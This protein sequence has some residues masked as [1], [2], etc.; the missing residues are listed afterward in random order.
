MSLILPIAYFPPVSYFS[1]LASGQEALLESEEHFVKQTLRNRC[2]I[3]GA[4]GTL[5]LTVP[6]EHDN[7]WRKPIRDLRVSTSINWNRIHWKS[8]VS[9][10]GKST[11]FMY[12]EEQLRKALLKKHVF[13]W[14][15]NT[16]LLN[17][18]AAWIRVP[19]P[20]GATDEYLQRHE[21]GTDLRH[22]WDSEKNTASEPK[23]YYQVFS[24][25]H[26]F[27]ED[28]SAIDLLFNTGPDAGSFL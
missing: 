26:G 6:V 14:D 20:A 21:G 8:I 25:R 24:E 22:R 4:N 11:Y 3:A 10:Y 7:R 28:L 13:L 1:A 19:L 12:Y 18:L 16:E 5:L 17:L 9:S 27:R 23:P 15:L 2:R